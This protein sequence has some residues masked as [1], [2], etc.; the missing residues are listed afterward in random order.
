MLEQRDPEKH[1]KEKEKETKKLARILEEPVQ[2]ELTEYEKEDLE[3]E[4]DDLLEKSN[5]QIDAAKAK[6]ID[7]I[8]TASVDLAIQAASKVVS[9]NMDDSTNREIA[10]ATINEA[11]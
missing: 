2:E 1:A 3:V 5:K 6:A 9:K 10:K 8:K 7:E 11:N 4:A